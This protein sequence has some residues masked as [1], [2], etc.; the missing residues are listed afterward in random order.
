MPKRFLALKA[1]QQNGVLAAMQSVDRD[2]RQALLDEWDARCASTTI[3]NPA[4]YL[5]GII[6]KALRGEFRI[7][8]GQ[9]APAAP[10]NRT[11]E[12]SQRPATPADAEVAKAHLARLQELLRSS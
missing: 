8:A 6:Q 1:E 12:P 7:W 11:P 9:K 10:V 3:R 2:L 5:F 4:G